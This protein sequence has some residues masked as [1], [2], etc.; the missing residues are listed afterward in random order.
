MKTLV[1][2]DSCLDIFK[3]GTSKRF[4]PE[5]P[6]PVFTPEKEITNPGMAANVANNISSFGVDCD[7]ITNKNEIS[8]IRFVDLKS[9]QMIIRVDENDTLPLDDNFDSIQEFELDKYDGLVI[10][11]YNKGFLTTENISFLLNA[12]IPTFLQTNKKLDDWCLNS[13]FIKI[14]ESE[15]NNSKE[16]IE[17]NKK[18]LETKLIVTVGENGCMFNNENYKIKNKKDIRDLSGAGDTFLAGFVYKYISTKNEILSIEF[19]QEMASAVIELSGVNVAGK[20]KKNFTT[21][22]L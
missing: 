18:N 20:S 2:G 1:I 14:N 10:S 17:A 5:A 16:F 6:V 19:A 3:Y 22:T 8:K 21:L 11:D 7:L 15:Y 4:S 13:N 12:K 9:K